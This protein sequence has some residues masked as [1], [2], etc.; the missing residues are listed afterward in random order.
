MKRDFAMWTAM[1]DQLDLQRTNDHL[2]NKDAL[3][4]AAARADSE[5]VLLDGYVTRGKLTTLLKVSTS[6]SAGPGVN[7]LGGLYCMG[8]HDAARHG[9]ELVSVDSFIKAYRNSSR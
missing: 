7:A 9:E 2:A 5:H 3:A 6:V 1:L 4:R 8:N